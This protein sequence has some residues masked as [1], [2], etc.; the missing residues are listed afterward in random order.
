MLEKFLKKMNKA[1]N[2]K[3]FTLVELIVVIAILGIL[4][5]VAIGRFG[6]FTDSA[7]KSRV[8]A[9]HS[10]LVSAIQ[11]WQSESENGS[12]AFP[13]DLSDLDKYV[14]GGTAELSSKK[15]SDVPSD[16]HELSGTKA[17]DGK[18]TSVYDDEDPLVYP[19]GPVTP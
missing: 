4:A 11:V 6:G 3:G 14:D 1:K 12:D 17:S 10:M 2:Q 5:A 13:S 18:L 9:E 8:V 15:D 7:K 19:K 16:A